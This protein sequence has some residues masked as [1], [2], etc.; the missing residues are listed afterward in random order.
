MGDYESEITKELLM[1]RNYA[2]KNLLFDLEQKQPLI[3]VSHLK[4]IYVNSKN[5][6]MHKIVEKIK[7]ISRLDY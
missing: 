7:R 2:T 1:Y 3:F 4:D 6:V 5:S